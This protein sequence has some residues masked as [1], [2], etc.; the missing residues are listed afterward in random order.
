MNQYFLLQNINQPP[1]KTKNAPS[2]DS[3][4]EKAINK[5]DEVQLIFEYI[6]KKKN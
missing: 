4:E 5:S 1:S 3:I 2:K 6:D